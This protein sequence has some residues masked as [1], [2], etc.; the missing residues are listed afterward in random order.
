MNKLSKTWSALTE[1]QLT[2][3]FTLLGAL[4]AW[5]VIYI[6]HGWLNDDSVLYFEMARLITIGEWKQATALFNWPLYPFL[7]SSV[8][9]L[10]NLSIHTSAQ[11]LDIAFF[12]VTVFSFLKL[13]QLAGGNRSVIVCGSIV[14]LS[15]SYIVGD[16]LPM[17]LRDQ[18]FWAAFLASL[19]FFIK[20]SRNK[21]LSNA[22][23]WQVFAIAAVLFRIESITFLTGIPLLLFWKSALPFHQN[24]IDYLKANVLLLILLLVMIAGLAFLPGVHLSDFGRLNEVATIVPRMMTDI[25]QSLK[26]KSLTMSNEVLGN[27]LDDYGYLGLL[28]TLAS[29]V[30]FKTLNLAS[31]PVVGV[32]ALNRLE[33]LNFTYSMQEDTRKLFFWVLILALINACV[34]ILSAFVLSSRYI[35]AMTFIIYIFAAFEL[36]GLCN[37][38]SEKALA[39]WKKCLLILIVALLC[40]TA[41]K[42]ILPKQAGYTFELDAASYLKIHQ[43]PNEKVFYVS[44]RLRYYMGS[45]YVGRGYD[46]WDYT[47]QAIEDGSIYKFDYLMI[48]LNNNDQLSDRQKILDE[49]LIQY[50]V[51]KEFYGYKNKKKLVLYAKTI[52]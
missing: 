44:P 24:L 21:T 15:S 6:Q 5:R 41:V 37:Q 26:I 27:F 52:G 16:A 42:N 50:K 9:Q 4:L 18:G 40:F 31:W 32:F 19:V 35:I 36:A 51:V 22:L 17:L 11:V 38:Y 23:C 28:V 12:A 29:I 13:L 34:I 48:N 30:I 8:H 10:S 2:W 46:Y 43:I 25:A 45:P 49:K 7:I 39:Y 1:K 33:P 14:L 3:L 47:K 20:Y